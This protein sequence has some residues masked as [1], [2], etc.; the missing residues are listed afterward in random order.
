M[1][2]GGIVSIILGAI[3]FAA[4][5]ADFATILKGGLPLLLILGG[6]L[7]VYVSLDA[8]HTR[9]KE[10]RKEQEER[11]EKARLDIEQIKARSEQYREELERLKAQDRGNTP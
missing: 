6:A 2:I 1:L 11:L 7:A 5:W 8:I 9:M 4:W 10:E 3:G